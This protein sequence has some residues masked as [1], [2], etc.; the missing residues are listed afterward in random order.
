[1][2]VEN[3]VILRTVF[4]CLTVGGKAFYMGTHGKTTE[5]SLGS[6]GGYLRWAYSGTAVALTHDMLL[7][8][9]WRVEWPTPEC[10]PGEGYELCD[11]ADACDYKTLCGNT[12]GV[13]V[14]VRSCPHRASA[15]YAFRRK[16][17]PE[18]IDSVPFA[19][20]DGD[21]MVWDG[22]EN[23]HLSDCT[24]RV[25]FEGY[26]F[27]EKGEERMSVFPVMY[28]SRSGHIYAI[29]GSRDEAVKEVCKAVRFKV[30]K[31]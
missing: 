14:N 6:V 28:R 11:E 3:N 30:Q 5:V 24:E 31:G 22:E 4:D 23:V 17:K 25:N 19:N 10:D 16:K 9:C 29:P 18:F 27:D 15:T 2:E 20:T 13:W 26:L 21:Y 7:T 12:W 1:M 8:G